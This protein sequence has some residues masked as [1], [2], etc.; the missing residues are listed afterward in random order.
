M[1]SPCP[2]GYFINFKFRN[3][4]FYHKLGKIPHKRHIQFRKPDNTLYAEQLFGTVGF[5][6]MYSNIYH[7][8]RPTQVKEILN[9]YSVAPKIAKANNIESRLLKGASS[10]M[11]CAKNIAGPLMFFMILSDCIALIWFLMKSS[12]QCGPFPG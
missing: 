6:G 3:M 10:P 4:P 8:H 12:F 11:N 2:K 1:K 9:Q 7:E 5:D